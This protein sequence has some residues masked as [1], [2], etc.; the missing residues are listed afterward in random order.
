MKRLWLILFLFINTAWGQ[1]VAVTENGEVV[2]LNKDGT[3]RTWDAD[4]LT[5][6]QLKEFL[7]QADKVEKSSKEI[8]KERIM[9]ILQDIRKVETK[10]P[11]VNDF[12]IISAY[13]QWDGGRFRVL[14]EIK[15]N[16]KI[17]AGVQVE[18]IARDKN[19]RLVDSKDFW[20]NGI[21]NIPPGGTSG[22][23]HTIT[24]NTRAEKITIKVISVTVW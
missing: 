2:I 22:I 8:K 24:N 18:A 15:N 19:G 6:G 13:S 3:W 7:K 4:S 12:E 9:S 20:P 17:A 5:V 23:G 10:G 14:G 16:G 11:S 1:K 21:Y